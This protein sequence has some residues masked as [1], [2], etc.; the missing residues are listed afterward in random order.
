VIA[1][2]AAPTLIPA[3]GAYSWEGIHIYAQRDELNSTT[4]G[5]FRIT[6]NGCLSRGAT[7]REWHHKPGNRFTQRGGANLPNGR[8]GRVDGKA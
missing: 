7:L 6:T 4:S 3:S 5:T 8:N 1:G 2:G